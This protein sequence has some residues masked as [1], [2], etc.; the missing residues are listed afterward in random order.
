MAEL[1]NSIPCS[2]LGDKI[3][4]HP[5]YQND[6]FKGD[7]LIVGSTNTYKKKT[8]ARLNEVDFT[9]DKSVKWPLRERTTWKDK[10][11]KEVK[12]NDL[13]S[14]KNTELWENNIL[15]EAR[16]EW[17][18]PDDDEAFFTKEGGD[19]LNKNQALNVTKK[20]GKK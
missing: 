8:A 7:G 4:K 13:E 1:R 12:Q 5:T 15:K 3:Y 6:F 11:A 9:I 2:S 18:D 16:P 20:A 10:I 17:V 14:V 19:I